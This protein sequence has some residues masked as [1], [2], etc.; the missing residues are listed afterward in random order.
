[1]PWRGADLFHPS[2]TDS[3]LKGLKG[4]IPLISLFLITLFLTL[5]TAGYLILPMMILTAIGVQM[6][7]GR[8]AQGVVM[9]FVAMAVIMVPI[10]YFSGYDLG[11][12]FTSVY[13]NRIESRLTEQG[14]FT[15]AEAAIV[16]FWADQPLFAVTGV[17]LGGSSFYVREYD[18]ESYEG[19]T[20]APRGIIGFISDKGIIGLL[21]FLIA[22]FKATKPLLL[23]AASDSPNRLVY[24]GILMICAVSTVMIFTAGQWHDEWIVVGL[25]CAGATIAERE[26]RAVRAHARTVGRVA[27][28]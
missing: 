2:H 17:G 18:T 7:I 25:L 11:E 6:R 5:S 3:V 10:V 19:F 16:E 24:T 12:K 26:L 14:L 1:M 4:E 15:Y 20:A 23:A 27:F 21:L 8:V 13:E 28:R 9:R 22:I